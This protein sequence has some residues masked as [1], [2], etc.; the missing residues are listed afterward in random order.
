MTELTEKILGNLSVRQLF[1]VQRTC[2]S[3]AETIRGSVKLQRQMFLKLDPS[4]TYDPDAPMLN[5]LFDELV[6]VPSPETR[7]CLTGG[8]AL[9]Q[10]SKRQYSIWNIKSLDLSLHFH[11]VQELTAKI[12]VSTH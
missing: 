3:F 4:I 12:Y 6:F 7:R 2:K 8:I 11:A 10:A 1:G 9:D 5:P